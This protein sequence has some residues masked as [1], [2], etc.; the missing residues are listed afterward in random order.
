MFLAHSR[1]GVLQ[2]VRWANG[3]LLKPSILKVSG[4]S[5]SRA[6]PF[7]LLPGFSNS[8]ETHQAN[9]AKTDLYC[10]QLVEDKGHVFPP[11]TFKRYCVFISGS[12]G[13]IKPLLFKAETSSPCTHSDFF[14]FNL[15][16]SSHTLLPT[17]PLPLPAV[18]LPL[19]SP[20]PS[21]PMS[22]FTC[23]PLPL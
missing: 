8:A 18:P 11:S 21:P 12:Q 16:P 15:P 17:L 23:F 5:A 10:S 4:H 7:Y 9:N 6:L 2:R 3:V 1:F 13:V 22:P 19:A 14:P 20:V